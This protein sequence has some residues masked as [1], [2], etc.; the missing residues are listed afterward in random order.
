MVLFDYD[1]EDGYH[2]EPGNAVLAEWKRKNIENY[3]LVPDAWKRAAMSQMGCTEDDL[4]AQ[5]VLQEIDAFFAEQNL[6]LP[7]G[8]TWREIAANIFEVVDGKRIL[9]ENDDSLFHRLRS[10]SPS[11]EIL[12]E[13]VALGMLADELHEDVHRFMG[14]LVALVSAD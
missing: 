12:R 11:V 9:F 8:S 10:S 14:R 13:N 2:P 3:L 6:T 7:P 4:F 1:S 5:Q